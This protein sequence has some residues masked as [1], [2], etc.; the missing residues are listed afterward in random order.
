MALSV[1]VLDAY[2]PPC[3]VLGGVHSTGHE[4]QRIV[5]LHHH[6]FERDTLSSIRYTGN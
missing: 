5:V 6:A 1:K 3:F 2:V 4:S